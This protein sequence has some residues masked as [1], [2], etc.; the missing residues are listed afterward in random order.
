M[1]ECGEE[2]FY[3]LVHKLKDVIRS[4]VAQYLRLVDTVKDLKSKLSDAYED[5][6][7]LTEKFEM[8]KDNNTQLRGYVNDY[9]YVLKALGDDKT[10]EIL[11]RKFLLKRKNVLT[12]E[13]CC[14]IIAEL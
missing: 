7:K 3:E 10:N 13:K 14:D 11:H 4:V 1:S 2:I 12:L 8:L 9:I 5:I 6:D